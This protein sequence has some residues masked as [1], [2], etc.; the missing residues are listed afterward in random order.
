MDT[1]A[2]ATEP[3]SRGIGLHGFRA[4]VTD[5]WGE[6]GLRVVAERLPEDAR[7]ATLDEI[8]L[9]VSWYPVRHTIAW[10]EAVWEGLAARDDAAFF[11]FIDRSIDLGF[12]RMRRF[13]IRLQSPEKIIAR[14]PEMWRYQHTHGTLSVAPRSGGATITLRDHPFVRSALVS[15]ATAEVFRH[16]ASMTGRPSVRETHGAEGPDALVVRLTWSGA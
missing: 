2:P 5:I 4:A 12:G 3:M 16:I 8:V 15:R 1:P 14:S 6:R 11:A 10:D 9:P 7:A 13:F